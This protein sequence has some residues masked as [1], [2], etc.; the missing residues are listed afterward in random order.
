MS[1][2]W[3]GLDR[4]LGRLSDRCR[5]VDALK[6]GKSEGP[7]VKKSENRKIGNVGGGSGEYEAEIEA[8]N[9]MGRDGKG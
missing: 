1:A 7:K 4:H 8:E 9:A 2:W 3:H 6:V 5:K